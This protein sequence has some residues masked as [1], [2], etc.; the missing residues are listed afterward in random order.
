M[1]STSTGRGGPVQDIEGMMHPWTRQAMMLLIATLL[2]HS[3]EAGSVDAV[4][5][6][7]QIGMRRSSAS[8]GQGDIP[9]GRATRSEIW[10]RPARPLAA[11]STIRASYT[12]RQT[13]P[14]PRPALPAGW[15]AIWHAEYQL[16][17]YWN[18]ITNEVTWD[19]PA[20]RPRPVASPPV[21][22]VASPPAAGHDDG[23]DN[24]AH[25]GDNIAPPPAEVEMEPEP[26]TDHTAEAEI[27]HAVNSP[28]TEGE[29]VSEP[30]ADLDVGGGLAGTIGVVSIC[31]VMMAIG[32]VAMLVVSI[33]K[34]VEA[35]TQNFSAGILVAA[36]AGELFPLLHG[37]GGHR[38]TETPPANSEAKLEK[39]MGMLV[40]FA[41]GLLLM[42]GQKGLL[43]HD[44]G[45]HG[46]GDDEDNLLLS[47]VEIAMAF[48][49]AGISS[50]TANE[51]DDVPMIPTTPSARRGEAR[52]LRRKIAAARVS[53][54][55]VNATA[56][57]TQTSAAEE[58]G[59]T[60]TVSNETSLERTVSEVQVVEQAVITVQEMQR[61]STK[62]HEILDGGADSTSR[63]ELDDE[64]SEMHMYVGVLRRQI[65]G[66]E[67]LTNQ[68]HRELSES[69]KKIDNALRRVQ[70]H[71]SGSNVSV[72]KTDKVLRAIEKELERDIATHIDTVK[73]FRRWK[74]VKPNHAAAKSEIIPWSLVIGVSIDCLVDG[75]MVGLTY[76]ASVRAGCIMAFASSIESGF[77][78]LSLSSSVYNS[79]ASRSKHLGISSIPILALQVGGIMAAL[80]GDT[81]QANEAAFAGFIMFAIVALLFLVTQELLL[82]AHEI[83]DEQA[84]WYV[85]INLFLGA[86][87]VMFLEQLVA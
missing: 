44:H 17:Y 66:A 16:Y 22:P 46:D 10:K 14:P 18:T 7:H 37:S 55:N 9:K 60:T 69:V 42:F 39:T 51:N 21:V 83:T 41:L 12:L 27:T 6:G 19:A 8:E 72:D 15:Q 79:T 65:R 53:A 3:S 29:M 2:L 85:N 75:L 68:Q 74:P 45:S 81:L 52:D 57:A 28:A 73:S 56:G 43:G 26:T 50:S 13:S 32:T 78:G 86:G 64:L 24:S 30:A 70:R 49:P 20:Y 76:K 67:P 35:A 47:D 48:N 87:M 61:L 77:L 38:R 25:G 23:Q 58:S 4:G 62:I 80:V 11:P 34:K 71:F 54:R 84:L 5:N 31:S 33:P 36:I 82:T 63:D 1:Q 40:G 59:V